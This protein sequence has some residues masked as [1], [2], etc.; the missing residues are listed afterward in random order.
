M[1]LGIKKMVAMGMACCALATAVAPAGV[2]DAASAR[3]S[4]SDAMTNEGT[5]KDT[6]SF[7]LVSGET[8]E[9]EMES[10]NFRPRLILLDSRQKRIGDALY[11]WGSY[12]DY[13]YLSY[14]ASS[15]GRVYVV[16]TSEERNATG[17]YKYWSD[18]D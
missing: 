12:S 5:Y 4:S 18:V 16:A 7:Y 11:S 17:S 15:S 1:K 13:A 10:D 3:L 2:V 9:F 6:Y 8:L 14:T